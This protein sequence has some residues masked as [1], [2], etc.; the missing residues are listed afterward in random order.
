[1]DLNLSSDYLLVTFAL[2][3]RLSVIAALLPL[4]SGRSVPV[5][6]RFALAGV[7]AAALSPVILND[8][9]L[10]AVDLTWPTFAGEAVR[11]LII[12][13]VLT[14]VIGIPFAAVRFA[15]QI[16]GMQIGFSM[17][18]T[19]DP[20]G[21]GQM[22]I[23]SNVYYILAV[24]LY[25]TTDAHHLMITAMTES[26]RLL[27][28]FSPI[29][30]SA[31]MWLILQDFSQY[32]RLGL[33]ISAP[34]AIVL[35]LVSA[36]MGFVVKTVPQINI[37]VVGFPIKIAVGLAMFGMS[38]VFFGQVFMSLID[39]MEYQLMQMLGALQG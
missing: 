12:G 5:L 16:V 17:V 19:L 13:I 15:G 8:M 3:L 28:I 39:G 1:M 2:G 23:L 25:F 4:I 14:F 20:Q 35:L 21:G 7:I 31:A 18:N 6:W 37:L 10:G 22:T 9:P 30:P 11:S 36:S 33:I 24:L 29:T 27:P 34:V 26:C 32:F 38:L